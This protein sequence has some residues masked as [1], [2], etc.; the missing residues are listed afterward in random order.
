MWSYEGPRIA[1][2]LVAAMSAFDWELAKEI[3]DEL[4]ARLNSS[5]EP[6]PVELV[7]PILNPLRR[8]RRL[9]LLEAVALEMYRSKCTS[10][11]VLRLYS[12]ALIDRGDL[13]TAEMMLRQMLAT[14]DCPP[15]ECAEAAGLLGRIYKQRYVNENACQAGSAKEPANLLRAIDFYYDVFEQNRPEYTWQGVN[16]AALVIRAHKDGV[17]LGRGLDSSQIAAEVVRHILTKLD[18]DDTSPWNY[19]TAAEAYLALGDN[20]RSKMN[21]LNFVASTDAGVDA[22]EIFSF[23]RQ[24][25]EVWC[26]DTE[27]EPGASIIPLLNAALLG[28]QGGELEIGTNDVRYGLEAIFGADRFQPLEWF[29]TG[30]TRCR[31]VARIDDLG[32]NRVGTAFLV[33]A[34]DFLSQPVNDDI[35]LTNWHVV[36]P[37]GS[38]MPGAIAP[39]QGVAIFEAAEG[40]KRRLKQVLWCSPVDQLDASLVSIDKMP[41]HCDSCPLEPPAK[42]FL[43]DTQNPQRLFLIGYPRTGSG[44]SFSLQDSLWL[45]ASETKLHYRTPADKGS[46]GSPVFDQN[47]WTVVGLHHKGLEHMPRLDGTGTYQANEATSIAAI[48]KASRIGTPMTPRS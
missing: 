23:R 4:V 3:C 30:L 8:K 42:P 27:S 37:A 15:F 21:A 18:R 13:T 33:K 47:F 10:P 24:L 46:S 2:R 25:Q 16:A 31:A 48:Q 6:F 36:A 11:V 7:K 40:L 22:F 39:E 32:G 38:M 28:K 41:G 26:V 34:A 14:P 20:E 5:D 43:N 45:A 44:L 29:H 1:A 17:T 12:Q 19:S 35:L 9:D